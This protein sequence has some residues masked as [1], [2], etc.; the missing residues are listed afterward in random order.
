MTVDLVRRRI[1][2]LGGGGF[3]S[4]SEDWPLDEYVL[5]LAHRTRPRICLL[6]TASGDP[7]DQIDR[8]YRAFEQHGCDLSHVSLFRLGSHAIDLRGH[9]LSRDVI[10]VGG[11]SL[12]NLLALWRVHGVDDLLSEAWQSGVALAGVSA[13]AM[14]WFECGVTRTHGQPALA[15]GLGL[16]PGSAS[17]HYASDPER[18]RVY[19]EQIAAGAPAGWAIEDGVGLL[20]AGRTFVEAVTA[21]ADARAFKVERREDEVSERAIEPRRLSSEGGV[22]AGAEPISITE[23]RQA[24]QRRSR[25]S[26]NS[27]RS[28]PPV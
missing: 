11:G 10:Y 16:L 17:V 13:G 2:A 5:T 27:F 19:R 12:K 8:F 22:A 25:S 21:R 6:P 26:R 9:L 23:Y 15:Q 20:F 7:E 4:S 3:T 24:A 1:L 28:N 14:C 18:R